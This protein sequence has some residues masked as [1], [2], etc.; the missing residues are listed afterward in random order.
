MSSRKFPCFFV[1]NSDTLASKLLPLNNIFVDKE[2]KILYCSVPKT[3]C[4]SM[5]RMLIESSGR[6]PRSVMDR[7]THI[8]KGIVILSFSLEVASE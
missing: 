6:I 5:K 2:R 3:G 8:G 4:T 7:E 1:E